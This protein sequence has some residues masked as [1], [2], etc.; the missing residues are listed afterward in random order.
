MATKIHKCKCHG[1]DYTVC[2]LCAHQYCSDIWRQCP[3]CP[4]ITR[5]AESIATTPF[6]PNVDAVDPYGRL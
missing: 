4:E 6:H 2:P 5:V 1:S 3:R